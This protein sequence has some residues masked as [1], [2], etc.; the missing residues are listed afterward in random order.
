MKTCHGCVTSLPYQGSTSVCIFVF[1]S[2]PEIT[3]KR[4][5]VLDDDIG[6]GKMAVMVLAH[7]GYRAQSETCP[8][9]SIRFILGGE[10]DILLTDYHMPGLDGLQVTHLLRSM[11]SFIPVILHTGD[12]RDFDLDDLPIYGILGVI[13][14]PLSIKEFGDAFAGII[15]LASN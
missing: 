9:K 4:V 12:S 13:K 3:G 15:E 8:A 2:P 1:M 6:M 5:L 7:L 11:G 10:F 14:K